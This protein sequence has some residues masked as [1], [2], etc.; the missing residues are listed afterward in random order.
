GSRRNQISGIDSSARR[1]RCCQCCAAIASPKLIV[2]ANP[3]NVEL[4]AK[5]GVERRRYK[6]VTVESRDPH[7]FGAQIDKLIFD[8]CT[9]MLVKQQFGPATSGPACPY[10][11]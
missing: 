10:F 6:T 9:P 11:G 5:G 1:A 8:L 2:Q 4:I 7:C 3:N